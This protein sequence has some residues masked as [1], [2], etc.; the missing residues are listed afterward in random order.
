[1]AV[2]TEERF[3]KA[4]IAAWVG[5][6]GN[7]AVSV[8]KGIVGIKASSQALIADAVHSA[9]DAAGSFA[10]LIGLR[11]AKLPHDENHPYA[12]GKARSIASIIVSVILLFAGIEMGI[13]AFKS[14]LHGVDA[15]PKSYA[16]IAIG[17]SIIVKELIF[18]YKFNLGSKLGSGALNANALEHRSDIYSSI[19]ALMGVLGAILGTYWGLPFFYYFDPAAGLFISLLVLKMGYNLVIEAIHHTLDDEF[20]QEDA[21][22]LISTVQRVKGVI[23]VDDLRAKVLGNDIIVDVKISVH[24]K[25]SVQEGHEIAK[26]TK[27]QLMKRFLHVS[28][29]FVQ[30]SPYHPGL[31]YK[32]NVDPDQDEFPTLIH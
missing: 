7:I 23:A 22:D 5:I 17:I 31:P 4:E 3:K 6:A 24:P 11:A 8:L 16:F 19:A 28:D 13:S 21:V 25:I 32:Y 30:V 27:Q 2:L 26:V 1:V 29:V 20:D 12:S 9:S 18:R 10:V 15:A 14:L